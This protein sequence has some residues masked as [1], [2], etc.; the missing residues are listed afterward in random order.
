MGKTYDA[1]DEPMRRWVG[2]QQMFFV[3]TAP[4]ATSGHINLSPKGHDALRIIDANTLA[5][6]DYGGS[7]VET[8]AHLR[9]NGRIVVMMCAFQGPPNIVRFHGRGEVVTP[10]DDGFEGLA[11]KFELADLGIRAIIKIHVSRISDSCGYGVPLYDFA[12]HRESSQN[13]MRKKGVE[14]VREYQVENNL[15]SIDD[16]PAISE[17]EARA[18][19]APAKRGP[20]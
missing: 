5:Y 6:L 14:A 8:I 4:A 3:G 12:G 18:Y 20:P 17:D 11:S 16:L 10:L 9:E 7:G 15:R 13:W 19:A 2:Q 1:I